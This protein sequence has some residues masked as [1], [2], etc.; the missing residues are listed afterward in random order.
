WKG[1]RSI[2]T[3]SA[4]STRSRWEATMTAS[5]DVDR[6]GA[7]VGG[8]YRIIRLLARGGM[9]VVYEAHHVVVRRRFAVKF[10]RRDLAQRRDILGRF[11]REAETAGALEN[12]NV[13]A[14]VDFG[15]S[16]DGAPYIVM[17]YLVGE[18]LADLL[19]REGRLP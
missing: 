1:R 15:I 11:Q 6:I 17:E 7:L 8:K 2:S 19:A 13:T 16:D 5:A 3:R 9:G 12:E 14:A 10:L 18:S 4:A